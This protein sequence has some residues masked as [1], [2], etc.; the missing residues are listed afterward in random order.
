MAEQEQTQPRL[1]CVDRNDEEDPDYPALLCRVC[2]V[3]EVLVDL[4]ASQQDCRPGTGSG[5]PLPW[6]DSQT[7]STRRAEEALTTHLRPTGGKLSS[8]KCD[9]W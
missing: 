6:Q 4:V 1:E 7:V 2:V 9:L 8:Q 3:S 5:K